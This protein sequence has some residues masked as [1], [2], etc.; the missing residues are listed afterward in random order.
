MTASINA[1]TTG[2]IVVTSDTSGNLDI[3]SGGSTKF[4]VTSSGVSFT[5]NGSSIVLGTAQASTS[6]TSIDFTGIPSWVKKITVMFQGVSTNGSSIYVVQLGTSGGF[7]TSGYLGA[8]SAAGSGATGT[9]I[10]AGLAAAWND[11]AANIFHGSMSIVNITGNSWCSSSVFGR[12]NTAYASVGGSSISLGGTLTQ[13][14]ITTV[15]GTDT[16]DAGSINI[17]YE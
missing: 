16:F 11:S 12:S 1:S 17:Q 5:P 3:Q 9:N 13:V 10:T 6:G 15:N 8:A 2:G 7:V 14:R 4:S